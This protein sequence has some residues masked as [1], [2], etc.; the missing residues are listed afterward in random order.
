MVPA[1]GDDCNVVLTQ[2]KVDFFAG[3]LCPCETG[4]PC[5]TSDTCVAESKTSYSCFFAG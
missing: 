3:T 1:S 2:D 4:V 5:K